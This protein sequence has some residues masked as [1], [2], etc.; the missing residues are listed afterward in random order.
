VFV[1][2]VEVER[3]LKAA[4]KKAAGK[5]CWGKICRKKLQEKKLLKNSGFGW[6]SAS[7]L[8]LSSFWVAALAAA[9]RVTVRAPLQPV[10]VRHGKGTASAVPIRHLALWL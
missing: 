3:S 1:T 4:E 7:A 10:P 8:R 6:R 5:N 9:V 2:P